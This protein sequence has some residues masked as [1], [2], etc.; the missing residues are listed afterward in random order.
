MNKFTPEQ[1]ENQIGSVHVGRAPGAVPIRALALPD[2]V[3]DDVG[4]VSVETVLFGCCYLVHRFYSCSATPPMSR[5]GCKS[6]RR[7]F[8]IADAFPK[9]KNFH[10]LRDRS[11]NTMRQISPD[12]PRLKIFLFFGESAILG[13]P[14]G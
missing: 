13:L 8:R 11:H 4:S 10:S 12:R 14:L 5:Y 1:I 3:A 2:E 9:L 7:H 6:F